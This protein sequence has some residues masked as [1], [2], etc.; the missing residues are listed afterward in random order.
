MIDKGRQYERE[1]WKKN[2]KGAAIR[3]KILLD[4][5]RRVQT[6]L[7]GGFAGPEGSHKALTPFFFFFGVAFGAFDDGPCIDFVGDGTPPL[8]LSA[9]NQ[10][11]TKEGKQDLELFCCQRIVPPILGVFDNFVTQFR[12]T[13]F[14]LV[15]LKIIILTSCSSFSSLHFLLRIK[16]KYIRTNLLFPRV[17]QYP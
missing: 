15:S 8:F 1:R 13:L 17:L 9:G 5:L 6:F 7:E 12:K 3:I 2:M 16:L 10:L 14:A 4:R 11:R